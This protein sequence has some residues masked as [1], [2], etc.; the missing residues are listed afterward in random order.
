M[1]NL[2]HSKVKRKDKV[3]GI[4]IIYGINGV[5]GSVR[6]DAGILPLQAG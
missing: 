4:F 3:E 6:A 2:I 1:W 5:V